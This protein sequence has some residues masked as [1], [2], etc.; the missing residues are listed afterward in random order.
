MRRSSLLSL[1][2]KVSIL[3]VIKPKV[4]LNKL[5]HV[6]LQLGFSGA[7]AGAK[8]NWILYRH[9]LALRSVWDK[10]QALTVSIGHPMLPQHTFISALHGSCSRRDHR[11]LLHTSPTSGRSIPTPRGCVLDI[12]TLF[13]TLS[14]KREGVHP[15]PHRL[16]I[17][18]TFFGTLVFLPPIHW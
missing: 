17:L 10:E 1:V 5:T 18:L 7:I 15:R 13:W 9:G 3:I 4:L 11:I 2:H 8:D 6:Q 12:Q 16:L 14:R